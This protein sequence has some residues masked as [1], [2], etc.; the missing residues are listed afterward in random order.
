MKTRSIGQFYW[1]RICIRNLTNELPAK[2]DIVKGD[3]VFE[4]LI[5]EDN[6]AS[7]G[8]TRKPIAGKEAKQSDQLSEVA[9]TSTFSKFSVDTS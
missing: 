9:A 2:I 3:W 8:S 5:Y 7:I 1:A 4:I 6:H